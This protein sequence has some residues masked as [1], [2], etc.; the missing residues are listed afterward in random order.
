MSPYTLQTD[1]GAVMT[2]AKSQINKAKPAKGKSVL[3]SQQRAMVL[4]KP[5][6]LGAGDCSNCNCG[7]K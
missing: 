1:K 4:R 3:W 5:T 6:K 7:G 2:K